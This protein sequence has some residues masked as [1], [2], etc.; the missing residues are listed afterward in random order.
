MNKIDLLKEKYFSDEDEYF[1]IK[2]RFNSLINTIINLHS[3]NIL[4]DAVMD[5]VVDSLKAKYSEK[6]QDVIEYLCKI[7]AVHNYE[8]VEIFLKNIK[9]DNISARYKFMIE[10]LSNKPV[11]KVAEI[12]TIGQYKKFLTDTNLDSLKKHLGGKINYLD[13]LKYVF[14]KL[15]SVNLNE[16]EKYL[17]L[18]KKIKERMN[19]TEYNEFIEENLEDVISEL[20]ILAKYK[21]KI[22]A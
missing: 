14:D 21:D 9:T 13:L 20:P 19:K 22:V 3:S 18:I 16:I 1:S 6:T 2:T 7:N 4:S 17:T 5:Y 10:D 11:K 15:V 8:D 12:D